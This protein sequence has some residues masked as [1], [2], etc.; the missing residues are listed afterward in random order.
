MNFKGVNT[1]YE[2]NK[3]PFIIKEE[4]KMS[5]TNITDISIS[6]MPKTH[7]TNDKV[8]LDK[9]IEQLQKQLE[10]IKENDK[11]PE[12]EKEKRIENIEKQISQIEQQKE[13]SKNSSVDMKNRFDTYEKQKPQQSAGIYKVTQDE[14]G[15][16]IVQVDKNQEDTQSQPKTEPQNDGKKPTIVKTTVNTDKID[17]EIEKL[18]QKQQQLQQKIATT[19]N[20]KE[21]ELL[22]AQ[23]SQVNAELKLKDND[24]YR[25]QHME[26]TE[27]KVV[28][29]VG[30]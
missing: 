8:S 9:K 7:Q 26:I 14:N 17:K 29:K 16:Q 20:P 23:L 13:N 19:K 24:T 28:S 12:D 10:Q 11:L 25:R 22:E 15:Q 27:Q 30:E 3:Q 5:I 1:N 2:H 4:L 21:K 18:K 6:T